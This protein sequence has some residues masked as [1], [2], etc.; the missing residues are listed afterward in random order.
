MIGNSQSDEIM[1]VFR[2]AVAG[3][4][5]A[6]FRRIGQVACASSVTS[7]SVASVLS[8]ASSSVGKRVK[9]GGWVKAARKQKNVTFI[10]IGDGSCSNR[11]QVIATGEDCAGADSPHL[12]YHSCVE[13]EGIVAEST[14]KANQEV[15][16][17]ADRI[18][19]VAAC[20]DSL[21]SSKSY[22]FRPR[23]KYQPEYIRQFPMFRAKLNDFA[24]LLRVRNGLSQSIHRH[25]QDEGFIQ[26]QTPLLTGNDCEGA[27]EIFVVRPR[28]NLSKSKDGSN[29]DTGK[30]ASAS[31]GTA[32]E[33]EYFSKT[34]FL[35]VSGQLH[36]EAVCN[37]LGKVYNFSPV[38]RAERGRTRRHLSEF[39]MVEAEEAFVT[40]T[41]VLAAR[42]ERLLKEAIRSTLDN[43]FQDLEVYTRLRSKGSK[44]DELSGL[45]NSNFVILGYNEAFEVVKVNSAAFQKKPVYGE[46]GTEHELYLAENYCGGKPV[47]V[48]DWPASSKP[49]YAATDGDGIAKA[50]DLIFPS[51]G[52]VAGGSVRE[53]MAHALEERLHS[54]RT[55][56]GVDNHPT[57]QWYS[58][59]RHAGSAPTAG[60]GLGFE[61][62]VQFMLGVNNIR[63]T[64]PFPRSPH[65]CLL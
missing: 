57:L 21:P 10:D 6:V 51:V 5:G 26:I 3:H 16:L 14:H 59:L 32:E 44:L 43:N 56:D 20:H 48:V 7:A 40:T 62:L 30:E 61:R 46:L 12:R 28:D 33:T 60:F 36:L 18:V 31:V 64:L 15:E 52:E 38:F 8:D 35:T 4:G 17:I 9:V 37:G 34:V 41:E 27:G 55:N 24:A 19:V 58:D 65:Q 22:P 11:L 39:T 42:I 53:H 23:E 13:V 45:L 1:N 25:F 50:L 29:I 49:F 54:M 63:D 2:V 47:F